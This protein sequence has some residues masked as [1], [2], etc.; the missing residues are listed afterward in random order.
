MIVKMAIMKFVGHNFQ[1]HGAVFDE[2]FCK[3]TLNKIS[4]ANIN[5]SLI[6]QTRLSNCMQKTLGLKKL[7]FSP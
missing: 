2:V 1:T 6:I 7:Y 4:K 5:H 3:T